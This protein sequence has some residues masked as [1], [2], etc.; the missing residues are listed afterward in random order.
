MILPYLEYAGFMLS[1]CSLDDRRELQICQNDALRICLQI[2]LNDRV[3]IEDIHARC[4]LVSLEQCRRIQLL[5]LLYK[6]KGDVSMHKVFPRNTRFSRRIV[7]KTD[8]KEVAHYKRSPYILLV[9]NYGIH[10]H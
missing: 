10:C 7:F 9:Q 4:K 8:S 3:R 2:K 1:V 5:L 6:K